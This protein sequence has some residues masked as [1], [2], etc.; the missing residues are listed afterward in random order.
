VLL[1]GLFAPLGFLS[2]IVTCFLHR[3]LVGSPPDRDLKGVSVAF[4]AE[5]A[6]PGEQAINGSQAPA[7]ASA[8][9]RG[10]AG[11]EPRSSF[12]KSTHNDVSKTSIDATVHSDAAQHNG[13]S[14]PHTEAQKG[15][16]ELES[17]C[18]ASQASFMSS[19]LTMCGTLTV[20]RRWTRAYDMLCKWRWGLA[21]PKFRFALHCTAC[22]ASRGHIVDTYVQGVYQRLGPNVLRLVVLLDA[23][24]M[25]KRDV[26][27][28]KATYLSPQAESDSSRRRDPSKEDRSWLTILEPTYIQRS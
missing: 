26:L 25:A 15:T 8:S 1:C 18:H 20:Q 13:T 28:G 19:L 12:S 22:F 14:S 11:E 21:S 17:P 2:H 24:R 6:A 9:G 27:A 3:R 23:S 7:S 5:I 10:S 4:A 16:P